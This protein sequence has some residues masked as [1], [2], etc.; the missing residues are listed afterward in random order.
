M[1]AVEVFFQDTG[2]APGD[3]RFWVHHLPRGVACR[4][5][6]VYVHPFAEEMNKSRRMAALQARAFARAGYRVLQIDLAGCGDSSGDFREATWSAWVDDVR[7]GT[8]WLA[9]QDAA[10]LWLW[11]LRAGCLLAAEAAARS[12]LPCNF[13][14]WQPATSGRALLQ[15][16]LRL[17]VAGEMA[18]GSAKG[19]M[20]DLK[21]R[22]AAGSPVE[23]AGYLLS[24]GLA[25]GLAAAAL[26]PAPVAGRVECLEVSPR[27]D[28]TVL[29]ATRTA[30][31]TWCNAGHS[32]RSRVIDGPAFWQTT[33]IEDAPALIDAS[34]RALEA[35]ASP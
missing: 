34:V 5:Q 4:G 20:D 10:P 25:D 11:G 21:G 35:T 27:A 7:R 12:D 24:P 28:A 26:T 23:V 29:P 19:V 16:F 8:R 3:Q 2:E 13:L 1:A 14:F 15:Q 33:E 18:S 9:E 31:D 30:L 22:L 17:R 6:I 32:V